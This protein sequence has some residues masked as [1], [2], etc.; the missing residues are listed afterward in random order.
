MKRAIIICFLLNISALCSFAQGAKV[1]SLQQVVKLH[2]KD[3]TGVN[4]LLGLVSEFLRIDLAKAKSYTFQA[5]PVADSLHHLSGLSASYLYLVA[6]YQNSGHQDSAG[7]YL[8]Q[9]QMLAEANPSDWKLKAN[10]NQ[11][12]GLYYKNQGDFKKALPYLLEN[13]KF[14][15]P[16]IEGT[17]GLY[18]NI[19]NAYFNLSDYRNAMHY[20]LEGLV[21]FE[22]VNSLRG[23]S[24]C[25]H[26]LGNDFFHL[27]QF[28][29]SKKYYLQAMRIKEQLNDKR[30]LITT[31]MGAGD[32]CKE[33]NQYPLSEKYY[34]QAITASREMKLPGEELRSLYQIGL[35]YKRMEKF[36][37]ARES[38]KNSLVLARQMGDSTISA[39]AKSELVGI[40]I[41]QQAKK[42]DENTLMATLETV[43]EAG[44]RDGE[45]IE[46]G[47]LSEYYAMNKQYEKAFEYLKKYEQLKDEIEG[48][49]VLLELRELEGQYQTEKKEREI[50]LLKKDQEL[51]ALALDRERANVIIIAIVLASVVLTALLLINRYRV[52]ARA[53]RTIEMERMRNAIA[54]DLHDDIGSTLSSIN[55]MSQLALKEDN[56]HAGQ[57]FQSIQEHS[58]K[59]MES[60]SDIVWSIN[61]N[62]DSLEQVLVKMKEFAAEILEPKG[63]AF[64]FQGID[65]VKNIELASEKRKNV[66]LIFKEAIN[67]AA[68]YSNASK[69]IIYVAGQNGNIIFSISDNGNGFDPEKVKPGNGL[70]NMEARAKSL[71]GALSRT[72]AIGNGTHINLEFPIT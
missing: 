15:K 41:A 12:A 18:L 48:T 68:K 45:L 7:H 1:D 36:E 46:Y 25:L 11:S 64:S 26:S 71:L 52:V 40:D 17:A 47:R 55:I 13:L 66:F 49:E 51:Q 14:A 34:L 35:L 61:P 10:Y 21:I 30:G 16:N 22:K 59:I 28:E 4:A 27:S 70:K 8:G 24:F 50:E 65:E 43:I 31:W 57:Y 60:M 63:I 32:V 23:Q 9:L 44:N 3:T 37:Q 2:P 53:K 54:R 5:I 19:G 42:I 67:N 62:N 69:I 56:G 58:S 72:S 20:H 6:L 29:L 38:I 39:K 33:S